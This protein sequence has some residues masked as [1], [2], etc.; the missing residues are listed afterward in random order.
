MEDGNGKSRA[1][2]L[3]MQFEMGFLGLH[4]GMSSVRCPL[5]LQISFNKPFDASLPM[6]IV[7]C[8]E[9]AAPPDRRQLKLYTLSGAAFP[10]RLK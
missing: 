9:P 6:P 8:M 5:Q 10:V 1:V 2:H 7:N 4:F 3:G